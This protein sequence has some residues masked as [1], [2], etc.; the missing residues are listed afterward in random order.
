MAEASEN[1][2]KVE[3]EEETAKDESVTV[4]PMCGVEILPDA[5]ECPACGEPFSP[6]AFKKRES[7]KDTETQHWIKN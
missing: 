4:C 6:E 3:T 1:T 7:P 5:I 2:A